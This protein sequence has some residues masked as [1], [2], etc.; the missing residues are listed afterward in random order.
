MLF[1]HPNY[2]SALQVWWHVAWHTMTK[3]HILRLWIFWLK[4]KKKLK[5]GMVMHICNPSTGEAEA[6]RSQT[7]A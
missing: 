4:K 5:P 7:R 6:G 3:L 1:Q 2:V